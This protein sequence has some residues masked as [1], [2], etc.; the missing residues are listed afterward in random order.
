MQRLYLF[1]SF[2][3]IIHGGDVPSGV[4]AFYQGAQFLTK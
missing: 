2:R 1:P 3:E 4:E